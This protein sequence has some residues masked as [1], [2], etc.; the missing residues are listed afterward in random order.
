[1]SFKGFANTS[2]LGPHLTR[3]N[4]SPAYLL[5]LQIQRHCTGVWVGKVIFPRG[6]GFLVRHIEKRDVRETGEVSWT[7]V[8][9]HEQPEDLPEK[10]SIPFCP[11]PVSCFPRGSAGGFLDHQSFRWL[12]RREGR[13]GCSCAW[14]NS[15]PFIIHSGGPA[16][17]HQEAAHTELSIAVGPCGTRGCHCSPWACSSTPRDPYPFIPTDL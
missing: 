9:C 4:F 5:L 2:E 16:L 1:M 6:F 14:G 15:G 12:R 10:V 13:W 17:Q 7:C 11:Q 8:W 3:K